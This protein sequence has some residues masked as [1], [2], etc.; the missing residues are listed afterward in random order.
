MK[1]F[2]PRAAAWW[3]D[4][5][6]SR[7]GAVASVLARSPRRAML[8]VGARIAVHLAGVVVL[9][10]AVALMLWNDFGPGPLD[11]FIVAISEQTGLPLA[12]AVWMTISVVLAVAWILGRRPGPG[13]I[14]T[15]VLFG[16]FVQALLELFKQIEA[17]SSWMVQ[18]PI[19]VVA[20]TLIGVG[21]GALIVSGLGAGSGELLAGAASARSG[22]PEPLVRLA[23]EA[24]WL[25]G[26]V[27]FGGPIGYGTLMMAAGIGP[28]VSGGHRFVRSLIEH[29][30]WRRLPSS[31]SIHR[32]LSRPQ[33]HDD[34]HFTSI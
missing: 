12:A 31:T 3:R 29:A 6:W 1:S 21:A 16:P 22:K 28:A 33:L 20:V 9:S 11:A 24:T 4:R 23:F 30:R 27:A 19:Q 18:A 34:R 25:A 26:A 32:E 8:A 10:A 13:S 15:A 5:A 17:P 14:L 2:S 7:A